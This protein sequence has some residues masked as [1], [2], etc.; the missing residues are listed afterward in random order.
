MLRCVALFHFGIK[1]VDT[2]LLMIV[3]AVSTYGIQ[4]TLEK[5]FNRIEDVPLP[6]LDKMIE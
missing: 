5:G 4:R 3:I 6:I 1:F 2:V